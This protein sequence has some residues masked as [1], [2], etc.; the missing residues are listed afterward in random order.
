MH[1]TMVKKR[2]AN[3]EPCPKCVQAEDL[4]KSRGLWPRID[5]VVW[6]NE[7]DPSSEGMQLGARY[8]VSLAPF[9]IVR[10]ETPAE[11]SIYESV[12]KLIKEGFADPVR[13]PAPRIPEVEIEA[14]AARLE[15]EPPS[16]VLSWALERYGASLG[17]AFSGAEDVV[18]VH[19]AKETGF[20]F[21]VFCLDTGRLHPETYRFID[22]VRKRYQVEIALISP[23]A[24]SLEA[25]VR[26]IRH[27]IPSSSIWTGIPFLAGPPRKMQAL[28]R[29]AGLATAGIGCCSRIPN[30][31]LPK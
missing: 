18:L 28:M 25:F 20:P 7:G 8:G 14:D 22:A 2:L 6:A 19:M 4:L 13:S 21:S 12:L 11:I 9:F 1:V 30:S 24:P 10:G 27:W 16:R 15:K 3:G 17:I 23:D 5:E 31:F 26:T 29:K